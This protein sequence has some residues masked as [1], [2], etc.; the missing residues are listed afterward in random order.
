MKIITIVTSLFIF[1]ITF[2]L[3]Q[4]HDHDKG[5]HSH[6]EMNDTLDVVNEGFIDP[7]GI[8]VSI[9]VEGMVCDFCAQS[10][11]KVFMKRDEVVGISV[12][13]DN[14]NITL[15]LKENTDIDNDVIE[16]LFLDAGFNATEIMRK[17]VNS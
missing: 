1:C 11:Q 12:D 13:L 9:L 7:K 15:V 6:H 4:E 5:E 10:I 3:A 2:A 17:K 16:E 14:Q 8:L